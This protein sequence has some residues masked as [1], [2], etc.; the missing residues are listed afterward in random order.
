MKS[1]G[2]VAAIYGY[3]KQYEVFAIEIYESLLNNQLEWLELASRDVGK[4]DDVYIGCKDE[5][6]AYQV[7]D[8]KGN[9]TFFKFF[10][11]DTTRIII[12]IISRH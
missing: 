12:S 2:E 5:I 11:S 9:L 1:K 8:V 10:Y 7:K 4:L 6:K 3:N